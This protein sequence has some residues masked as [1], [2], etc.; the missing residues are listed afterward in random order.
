M[1]YNEDLLV[2]FIEVVGV[3]MITTVCTM[4]YEREKVILYALVYTFVPALL[5][6]KTYYRIFAIDKPP[7]KHVK[8]MILFFFSA[9]LSI[10]TYNNPLLYIFAAFLMIASLLMA[11]NAYTRT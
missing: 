5:L 6:I 9:R 3:H 10:L 4:M 11:Y 8:A 2:Y 1:T 7:K